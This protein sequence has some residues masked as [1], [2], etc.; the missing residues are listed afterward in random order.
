M[1]D[2][3]YCPSCAGLVSEPIEAPLR[4]NSWTVFRE[5]GQRAV[6]NTLDG[7]A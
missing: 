1:T 2:R 5:G 4:C 6:I 3:R 7:E